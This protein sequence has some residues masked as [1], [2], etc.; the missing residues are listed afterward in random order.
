MSQKI[1]RS[2]KKTHSQIL[3]THHQVSN[4]WTPNTYSQINTSYKHL[5][6]RYTLPNTKRHFPNTKYLLLITMAVISSQKI[7]FISWR[8]WNIWCSVCSLISG[9]FS[10]DIWNWM[11]AAASQKKIMFMCSSIWLLLL[12]SIPHSFSLF[13]RM[14]WPFITEG[15]RYRKKYCSNWSS[16]QVILC[17][18][19]LGRSC[20]HLGSLTPSSQR[21]IA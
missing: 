15:E 19:L 1:S 13:F 3:N 12:N 4:I 6:T 20:R 8:V 2:D 16:G 18:P 5:N 10:I 11:R 14:C 9:S 17:F 21:C 7:D